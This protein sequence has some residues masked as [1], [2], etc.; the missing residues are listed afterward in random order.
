M[1]FKRH[2]YLHEIFFFI[3]FNLTVFLIFFT[4]GFCSGIKNV[5]ILLPPIVQVGSSAN[6]LCLFDVEE[7]SLY[8]VQWYRGK[9]EFYRYLPDEIPPIKIFHIPGFYVDIFTSTKHQVTLTNISGHV[10]G[11]FSCEITT[12]VPKF[13]TCKGSGNLTVVNLNINFSVMNRHFQIGDLIIANCSFEPLIS[14]TKLIFYWNV[15]PIP[16]K[17]LKRF[18]DNHVAMTVNSSNFIS[19]EIF[20]QLRCA[21]IFDDVYYITSKSITL[22]LEKQSFT[23]IAIAQ[24]LHD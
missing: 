3:I 2:F 23:L 21:A 7:D 19:D 8:S 24:T 18:N 5:R 10:S 6:L 14:S 16:E 20:I 11:E 17:F 12:D 22:R 13:K 15:I 4:F 9:F 1:I